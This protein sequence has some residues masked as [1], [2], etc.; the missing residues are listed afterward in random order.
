M[1]SVVRRAGAGLGLVAAVALGLGAG[2]VAF[3]PSGGTGPAQADGPI[4]AEA[5]E[6]SVGRS[7]P[8]AVTVTQPFT[9]VATNSLAGVVTG[10]GAADVGLGGLLYEVAGVPVRAIEGDVPMYRDLTI[11]A[12]GKDVAELQRA[13]TAMGFP[14]AE[15][16]RFGAGTAEAVRAWQKS[17][18][19]EA[20]GAVGLGTVLALPDL[21]A[22]VR[23]GA[24]IAVGRQVTGAEDAVL[25]RTGAPTFVVVTTAEIATQVPPGGA[26]TITNDG[27][28]WDAVVATT[29]I[30][31]TGQTELE[32]TGPSGGAPCGDE[33]GT[34]PPDDSASLSGVLVLAPAVSGVVIPVA[35][36]QVDASGASV[37]ELDDGSTVPVDVV[38][39]Q[40]G[41]AV[42]EGIV[43]GQRVQVAETR[44]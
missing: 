28:T 20:T 40:D 11:G 4:T 24:D 26:V 8:V 2:Y 29:R 36:V 27:A 3:R 6:G 14:V 13:L 12:R 18:G 42:V 35:A 1:T 33:C 32:L 30:D 44:S 21:P 15:D 19:Q 7:I 43:A 41:R 37:V 38:A 22:T 9:T 31:Q 17:L 23:L 10:V 16:G 34:L 25:T 39:S 5:V